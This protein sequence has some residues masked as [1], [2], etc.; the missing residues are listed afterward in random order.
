MNS[1][2]LA[3]GV[4]TYS[5]KELNEELFRLVVTE[6]GFL[7][8]QRLVDVFVNNVEW[9]IPELRSYGVKLQFMER[10]K[11]A[12]YNPRNP[13]P[14]FLVS[15]TEE[16]HNLGLTQ[17][18][19]AIAEDLGVKILD[20]VMITKLLTTRKTV[21]GAIAIEVKGDKILV[22]LA[23]S[24]ILAT[25]GGEQVYLRLRNPTFNKGTT[26]D[27]YALAYNA[28]AELMDMEFVTFNMRAHKQGKI[29]TERYI[30]LVREA[31][32]ELGRDDN[33]WNFD[34][35]SAHYFCAGIRIDEECK[36]SLDNLYAAG[37]VTGGVFGAGRLGGAALADIIVFGAIAGESAAKNSKNSEQIYHEKAQV[38]EEKRRFQTL[39]EKKSNIVTPNEIKKDI[40]SIT[41]NYAGIGRTEELL[42][43]AVKQLKIIKEKMVMLQAQNNAE[44]SD[45]MEVLNIFDVARMV[46]ASALKRT[47]SRGAHWRLDYPSPDNKKWLKNIFIINEKKMK[48]TTRPVVKTRFD[49]P[50]EVRIGVGC[51]SGY[52][53]IT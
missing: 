35:I 3:A 38:D 47:E 45:A 11:V 5:A 23:K 44:L 24:T 21:V 22:L 17:P 20:D 39:L 4:I 31:T 41:Y 28:G 26:G 29:S 10:D 40:K 16:T 46:V 50:T 51:W 43:Q 1:T 53:K 52:F 15:R 13:V 34:G 30:E 48:I 33:R 18:L 27:G 14:L 19:R 7:N 36:T 49:S 25:G 8:N 2:A 42:N 9:R 6:G 12:S 32:T 37:E